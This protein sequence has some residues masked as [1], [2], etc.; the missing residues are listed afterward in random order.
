M[1]YFGC[2]SKGFVKDYKYQLERSFTLVIGDSRVREDP[3]IDEFF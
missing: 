3:S 1:E 2:R